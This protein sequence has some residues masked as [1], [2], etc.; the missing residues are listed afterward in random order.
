MKRWKFTGAALLCLAALGIGEAARAEVAGPGGPATSAAADDYWIVAGDSASNRLIAFDPAATNWNSVAAEKWSWKPTEQRRFSRDEI[1]GFN[2]GTDFKLRNTP[3]AGE[4]RMVVAAGWGLA[5]VT[6]YPAGDRLWAKV[7]PGNLHSIELLPDGNVALAASDGNWVRVYAA[8]QGPNAGAYAEF[9]LD[10]A[11][12]TLWDPVTMRLWVTGYDRPKKEHILTALV[13]GGT[14]ARPT[15]REDTDHRK[16][17]PTLWGHDVYPYGHDANKLWITTNGGSYVYDKSTKELTVPAAGARTF[18]KSVG[19]QPSGQIVQ[20]KADATKVPV[21]GCRNNGWC[22]DTVDFF[23]P[24]A[25]RTRTNAQFYKAR[26]WSPHYNVVDQP[27]RGKVW[28][29]VRGT[30]GTWAADTTVIDANTSVGSAA[31]VALPDGTLHQFSLVPGVGVQHRVRD[32]GGTWSAPT[33]VES[34]ASISAISAAALPDGTLHL[35]GV[36]PGSGTWHR[37]RT[38]TG[39]WDARATQ[40]D[41]NRTVTRVASAGLPDGTLHLVAV[42]PGSGVW[43]RFRT[44]ANAWVNADQIDTNGNVSMVSTAALPD[45]TLH[46][47]TVVPGSGV[48][49]RTRNAAGTWAAGADPLN[50]DTETSWVSAAGLPDGTLHLNTLVSGGG[51]RHLTRGVGAPWSAPVLVDGGTSVLN[52]FTAGLPDGTIHLGTVLDIS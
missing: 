39:T 41:F 38:A 29:R 52:T 42:V 12:A 2:G 1:A 44:T 3:K 45:G 7:L 47:F 10:Q 14:P 28:D 18:V 16:V 31:A 17:L 13:V 46:A 24:N 6:T 32:T 11:H 35:F 43:H 25:T 30:D 19:N 15:L 40:V 20:T 23:T 9:V 36:I 27:M 26:V 4:Q 49:H 5:A 34:N 51:V 22:T 48:W 8:S 37:A 33:Q 50:L 21:G